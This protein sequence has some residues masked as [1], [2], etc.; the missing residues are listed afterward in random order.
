ME[1]IYKNRKIEEIC[2]DAEVAGKCFGRNRAEK[3]QAR[4]DERKAAE[5]VDMMVQCHIGRCH[6]LTRN[7]KGQ[8]AVDLVHPKRLVFEKIGEETNEVRILEIV[9][10]HR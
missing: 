2:T 4:I 8:Y 1:I 5:T 3:I 10:Y 6:H 9:D 7:R